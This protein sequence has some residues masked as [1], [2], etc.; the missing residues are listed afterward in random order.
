MPAHS[1]PPGRVYRQHGM[2]FLPDR[3]AELGI[4]VAGCGGGPFERA[5][6]LH[7]ENTTARAVNR[8]TLFRSK[9]GHFPP[10]LDWRGT[11][12]TIMFLGTAAALSLGVGS[13]Y[14]RNEG[15]SAN[16]KGP[17]PNVVAKMIPR[18]APRPTPLIASRMDA[19]RRRGGTT[20][21]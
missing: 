6:G 2:T 12:K 11:M 7:R 9:R 8:F 16:T 1:F 5:G 15:A 17:I 20:G 21:S 19:L 3:P 10:V 18:R 14:A 13:A 4:L